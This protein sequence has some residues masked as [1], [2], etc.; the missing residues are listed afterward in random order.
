MPAF[1]SIATTK[2]TASRLPSASA[3]PSSFH[4]AQSFS[5]SASHDG[6]GRLPTRVAAR[7]GNFIRF[8]GSS[9]RGGNRARQQDRPVHLADVGTAAEAHGEVELVADD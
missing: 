5:G 8:S 9:Q 4:G 7:S 2:R 6:L 3:L 1:S